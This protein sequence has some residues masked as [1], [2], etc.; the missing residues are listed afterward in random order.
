MRKKIVKPFFFNSRSS[1][2]SFHRTGKCE[3]FF[4][5]HYLDTRQA[6]TPMITKQ[7]TD[8]PPFTDY[9]WTEN[10]E[11]TLSFKTPAFTYAGESSVDFRDRNRFYHLMIMYIRT[12]T[13]HHG[14]AALPFFLSICFIRD[15]ARKK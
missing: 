5:Y 13:T 10:D 11:P 15:K 7:P 8:I 1:R 6:H 3:G 2:K 12:W 4:Y 14:G 9:K